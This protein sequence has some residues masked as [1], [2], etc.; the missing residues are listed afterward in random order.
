MEGSRIMKWI[1]VDNEVHCLRDWCKIKNL[2]PNTI[3]MRIKIGWTEAQAIKIPKGKRRDK[4]DENGD[5]L[6][7]AE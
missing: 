2:S 3:C 5:L 4:Y 6:V 7:A 1:T